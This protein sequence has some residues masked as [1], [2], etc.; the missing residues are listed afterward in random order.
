ME[1]NIK[2]QAD[3]LYERGLLVF[4]Q[5]ITKERLKLVT[6]LWQRAL[7]LY[8][9]VGNERKAREIEKTLVNL[10]KRK[11]TKT[12]EKERQGDN[13]P[14][15]FASWDLFF[16]IG[17]FGFGGPMAVFSLLENELVSRK[18]ILSH[19]DFLEGAVLGDILPGPVTMDIVTY[20]GY[21]LKKWSGAIISTVVFILPSFIL[22]IILA[23]LYNK[24]IVTPRVETIFR[25]LGAAVTGL[26]ISVGLKLGEKE[27]K[28]YPAVG[29]FVWAFTSSLI[30]K[31]DILTV[32]GLAG[33]AGT[34]LYN[35]SATEKNSSP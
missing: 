11:S 3:E 31:F 25:C 32:V 7:E 16:K 21:K 12:K 28:D 18:K 19:E 14:I 1:Q 26:I 9:K 10:Y 6:E 2:K 20:A 22:M 27:I 35:I 29:I 13:I 17:C 24:Y 33:I 8:R 23:M 5:P 4:N 34:I 15:E 30:F